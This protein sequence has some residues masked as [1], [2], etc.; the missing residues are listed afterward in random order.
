MTPA[1]QVQ[2]PGGGA[3]SRFRL[4][5]VNVDHQIDRRNR[6]EGPMTP[7]ISPAAAAAPLPM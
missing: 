2:Q 4:S 6:L 3:W 7:I 1:K 5:A